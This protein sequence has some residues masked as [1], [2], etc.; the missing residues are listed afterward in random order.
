MESVL[1]SHKKPRRASFESCQNSNR[2]PIPVVGRARRAGSEFLRLLDDARLP[3]DGRDSRFHVFEH[4]EEYL[5]VSLV[6]AQSPMMMWSHDGES[7][8]EKAARDPPTLVFLN[9]SHHGK[10]E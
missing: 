9:S 2:I 5:A 7:V 10:N 8:P 4:P 6:S 3:P 1:E